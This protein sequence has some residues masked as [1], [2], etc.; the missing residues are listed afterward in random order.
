[1]AIFRIVQESLNN[2]MKHAVA[3][4]ADISFNRC[5]GTIYVEI[6]DDGRGMKTKKRSVDRSFGIIGMRER[7]HSLGATFEITSKKGKGTSVK[8]VIPCRGQEGTNAVSHC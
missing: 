4:R 8:L 7:A 5:G 2:I 1:M 3:S 6:S